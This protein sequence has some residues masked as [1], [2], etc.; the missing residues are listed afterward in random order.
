MQVT[1]G[2]RIRFLEGPTEDQNLNDV[3]IRKAI[4]HHQ[5]NFTF[6]IVSIMLSERCTTPYH[7]QLISD[8][9]CI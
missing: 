2:T 3:C 6:S 1:P 8:M 5:F 7:C 4:T 9:G